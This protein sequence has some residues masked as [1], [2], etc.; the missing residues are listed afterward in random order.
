[1]S[2]SWKRYSRIL[3]VSRPSLSSHL[4]TTHLSIDGLIMRR[5]IEIGEAMNK[6]GFTPVTFVFSLMPTREC[7]GE[8]REP[9]EPGEEA[10]NPGRDSLLE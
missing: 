5:G 9:Q 8:Y 1:M 4:I 6:P 2:N 3:V 10:H 7:A